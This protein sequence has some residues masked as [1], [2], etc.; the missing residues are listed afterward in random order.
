MNYLYKT[1]I[2][3]L[4]ASVMLASCSN[5]D[6][7]FSVAGPDDQP[8]ILAPTFPDRNNGALPIIANISRDG[9]FSMELTVTPADY[10][11]VVWYIDGEEAAAG[12][13]IDMELP[14]GAYEMKVVVTT[15]KGLSTS[16]E[17]IVMV[18]PLE[19]DPWATEVSYERIIAP[20]QTATLYGRNLSCVK[21]I[22]IG[23]SLPIP[24]SYNDGEEGETLTYTVPTDITDGTSRLFLVDNNEKEYGANKITV[25]TS[26]LITSGADR[27]T[28]NSTCVLTGI[29]LDKI[30][31]LEIGSKTITDFS[32]KSSMSLAFEAPNLEDGE[33]A[34]SGKMSNGSTVTFYKNGVITDNTEVVISSQQTLWAGHHYVSWDMPDDSPNK[35]FNLIGKDVFATIK[36]GAVMTIHYSIETSAEYHQIRTTSAWW[37]DLPGTGTV[38]VSEPGTLEVVLTKDC[39]NIIQEQDGFLCVGHGYFVD[40]VTLR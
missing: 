5:N 21:A 37:N 28:A 23:K 19:S 24:V 29:N 6:E 32:E 40:L 30:S 38:E 22:K 3:L 12:K 2:A 17:G 10:V 7:P 1:L 16:R 36:A 33:Y 35:T 31:S 15:T 4:P 20:G 11:D 8:H 26:A 25:S 27:M 13:T 14:S 39:L 18:N 34:F 9:N